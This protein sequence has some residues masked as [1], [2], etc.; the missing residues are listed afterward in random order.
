[1]SMNA[2][3]QTLK[4]NFALIIKAAQDGLTLC[5]QIT[6]DVAK[7]DEVSKL[8]GSLNGKAGSAP[9][10]PTVKRKRRSAAEIAAEKAAAESKAA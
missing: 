3:I 1:M 8:L 9:G 5:D 4:N 6:S 10:Q 2:K 7:I